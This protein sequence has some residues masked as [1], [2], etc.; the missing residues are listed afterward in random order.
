MHS[1]T[2]IDEVYSADDMYDPWDFVDDTNIPGFLD[3]T[4]LYADAPGDA[5]LSDNG[6]GTG[7]VT[8]APRTVSRPAGPAVPIP[9][10]DGAVISVFAIAVILLV[11]GQLVVVCRQR[12]RRSCQR[13]CRKWSVPVFGSLTT[14]SGHVGVPVSAL[15]S[16]PPSEVWTALPS[17]PLSALFHADNYRTPAFAYINRRSTDSLPSNAA[18]ASRTASSGSGASSTAAIFVRPGSS[19]TW[20][21]VG[22]MTSS[23]PE[24][25]PTTSLSMTSSDDVDNVEQ[26]A[27][28][29]HRQNSI[30]VNVHRISERNNAGQSGCFDG[31]LA[32]ARGRLDGGEVTAA[33][34]R[35]DVEDG[36]TN[37]GPTTDDA[38]APS[39]TSTTLPTTNDVGET[40]SATDD[41]VIVTSSASI[42][43]SPTHSHRSASE[44]DLDNVDHCAAVHHHR[45]DSISINVHRI[46]ARHSAGQSASFDRSEPASPTSVSNSSTDIHY[47]ELTTDCST[48]HADTDN[49]T[50]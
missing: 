26:C 35:F 3:D 34:G 9:D 5:E 18:V 36:Q 4:M 15:R 17:S 16:P 11:V 28:A 43:C 37:N 29:V 23:S 12:H 32:A 21:D 41:D 30:S 1:E 22:E 46:S 38:L 39:A 2:A 13:R 19:V 25:R 47:I 8:G 33:R 31:E 48:A 45:Q 44:V 42:S 27:A 10:F 7:R 14:S 40:F 6:T 49:S 50:C 24:K 20:S